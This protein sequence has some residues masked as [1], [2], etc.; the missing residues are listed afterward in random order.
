MRLRFV[1][2]LAALVG[3][4]KEPPTERF[5]LPSGN[6]FKV[7]THE[8]TTLSN[9]DVFS[10]VY[11][12]DSLDQDLLVANAQELFQWAQ[13]D[14]ESAGLK[15]VI[16]TANRVTDELYGMSKRITGY[17]VVY[18]REQSGEWSHSRVRNTWQK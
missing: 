17:G 12:T 7:Q 15:T 9:G 10:V 5:T 4:A 13:P 16:I 18:Q 11:I 14:A 1:L 2:L 8:Q 3:C 6:E